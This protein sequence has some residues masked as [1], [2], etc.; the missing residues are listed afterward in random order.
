M[1]GAEAQRVIV[2]DM[3]LIC[4]R[5]MSRGAGLS[6]RLRENRFISVCHEAY[7]PR[8]TPYPHSSSCS[9]EVAGL[10]GV[11]LPP[12]RSWLGRQQL[13]LTELYCRGVVSRR[14]VLTS[15]VI[16]QGGYPECLEPRGVPISLPA[17]DKGLGSIQ[18][19]IYECSFLGLGYTNYNIFLRL[20]GVYDHGAFGIRLP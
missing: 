20:Y 7:L 12:C 16:P 4:Q 18:A 17:E 5:E 10:V 13:P 3:A 15:L 11:S 8:G 9:V 19:Y 6:T 2:R 1:E 14:L